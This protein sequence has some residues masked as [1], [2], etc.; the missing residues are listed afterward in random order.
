MT[1][2]AAAKTEIEQLKR[3]L[4]EARAA[5]LYYGEHHTS[6]CKCSPNATKVHE[7]C[8]CG[9]SHFLIGEPVFSDV[10]SRVSIARSHLEYGEQ[11]REM[12]AQAERFEAQ[13]MKEERK[14]NGRGT[15]GRRRRA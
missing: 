11:L 9:L 3:Q 6:L 7:D 10:R 13:F 2:L 14:K 12:Q 4:E 8:S 15:S 1:E 5:V